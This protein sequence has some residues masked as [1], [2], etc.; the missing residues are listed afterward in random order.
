MNIQKI[1][2]L[3]SLGDDYFEEIEPSFKKEAD[4]LM[5]LPTTSEVFHNDQESF[6]ELSTK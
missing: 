3:L 5:S 4:A 2:E 6:V 1:C